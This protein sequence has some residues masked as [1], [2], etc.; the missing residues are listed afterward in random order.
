MLRN[1]V[2]LRN[3]LISSMPFCTQ[4]GNAVTAL[5]QFCW[6]CGT[7]QPTAMAPPPG[8]DPLAGVTPRTAAVLSYVP[9]IGWIACI[10]WL[11]SDRFRHDRTVRFHAFQGLYLFVAWLMNSWVIHPLCYAAPYMEI[12]KLIHLALIIMAVFMMIKAAHDQA[13]SLPLFGELAAR[14]VAES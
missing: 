13:Y 3:V 2:Q 10:I 12:D 8:P 9:G 1:I 4:C 5:D 6:R 11:A 7:R 14:S